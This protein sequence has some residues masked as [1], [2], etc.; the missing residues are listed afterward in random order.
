[1]SINKLAWRER[2]RALSG[3]PEA[4]APPP[5]LSLGEARDMVAR[6]LRGSLQ[7]LTEA[8]HEA[9][10]DAAARG[11]LQAHQ[12]RG[13]YVRKAPA[14]GAEPPSTP[15]VRPTGPRPALP[16]NLLAALGLPRI[17]SARPRQE[18]P[19]R[20]VAVTFT[21]TQH[22]ELTR[23]LGGGRVRIPR[24]ESAVGAVVRR[25]SRDTR[26]EIVGVIEEPEA[27][28]AG[29]HFRV[30]LR[31]SDERGQGCRVVEGA[32]RVRI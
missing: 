12:A 10:V 9:A 11:Y 29:R 21:I 19:A 23:G 2:G 18:E 20:P 31:S 17:E 22:H 25:I 8:E 24:G 3:V 14:A 15:R 7:G 28:G 13:L 5:V 1:M 30:T 26:C 27:D 32:I 6:R 16:E 4:A